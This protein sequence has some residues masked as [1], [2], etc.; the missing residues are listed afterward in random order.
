MPSSFQAGTFE[1]CPQIMGKYLSY[2]L[3][4]VKLKGAHFRKLQ[5]PWQPHLCPT[6]DP[7]INIYFRFFFDLNQNELGRIVTV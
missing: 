2:A 5:F 4:V 3:S 1:V 6:F 7:E